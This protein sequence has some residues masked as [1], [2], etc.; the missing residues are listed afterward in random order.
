MPITSYGCAEHPQDVMHAALDFS[1]RGQKF[2]LAVITQTEGGAVRSPGAMM[3]I[4]EEG[5]KA[6]YL[7]GGCIDSDVCLQAVGAIR[8]RDMRR[9]RYG[10]GSPFMDIR[11]PCGGAIDLIVIPEPGTSDLQ[12]AVNQ[13]DNRISVIFHITEQGIR[14][15]H[16]SKDAMSGFLVR[17]KLKLR[18]AGKGYEPIALA[19]LAKAC[20]V[21][22]EIWSSDSDCVRDAQNIDEVNVKL[23]DSPALLPAINDDENTAFVLMFHDQDWEVCLLEQALSG[24]AFFIG[25]VGSSSTHMRRADALRK[26]GVEN[27]CI[28]RIRAPLGL[29]PSMRDASMLAVSALAEIVDAYHHGQRRS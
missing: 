24:E 15:G 28:D 3:A 10:D 9:L 25:A 29:V 19:K 27:H 13:L 6:G 2:A 11:L 26:V 1:R 17:P 22:T 20:G 16:P 12:N 23:L 5:E 14:F 21:N 18:I 8:S 7:S 4:S